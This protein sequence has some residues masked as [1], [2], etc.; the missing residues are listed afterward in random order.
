[1][2]RRLREGTGRREGSGDDEHVHADDDDHAVP[3][4]VAV[5]YAA[6]LAPRTCA[7]AAANSASSS[8]RPRREAVRGAQARR[9]DRLPLSLAQDGVRTHR[10]PS[11]RVLRLGV[12][13]LPGSL[14]SQHLEPQ[15][16]ETEPHEDVQRSRFDGSRRR[17]AAATSTF[18]RADRRASGR[19][20]CE[21][22]R[23]RSTRGTSRGSVNC[24]APR[25]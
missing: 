4:P 7:L 2:V 20:G 17:S 3:L 19:A 14:T 5:R 13:E 8:A 10:G 11:P 25:A 22:C 21:S 16:R 1:V 12:G 9:P 23:R 18:D 24:R 6:G 15:D